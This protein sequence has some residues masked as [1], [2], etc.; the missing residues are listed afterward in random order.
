[1][2][3]SP[4]TTLAGIEIDPERRGGR[5]VLAGTGFTIAQLLAEIADGAS[6]DEVADNFSLDREVVRSALFALAFWI[7]HPGRLTP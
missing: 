5:P 7:D 1:M 6:P 3:G 2:S 4:Q